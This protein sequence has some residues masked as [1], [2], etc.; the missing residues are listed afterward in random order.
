[1]PLTRPPDRSL[2][3][4][5]WRSLAAHGGDACAVPPCLP[6]PR[7]YV[8]HALRDG[9]VLLALARRETAPAEA[10][11]FL[12]RVG[13]VLAKY[14]GGRV[15]EDAIRESFLRIY[16]VLEEV[17]DGGLPFVTEPAVLTAMLPPKSLVTRVA[18]AV[19][20]SGGRARE[21]L[22]EGAISDIPWRANKVRHASNEIYFDIVDT[23]DATMNA[24][25]KLVACEVFSRV[26]ANCKLSGMPDLTLA[27][28]DTSPLRGV[29]FN[30]CVRV[31][32]FR[33]DGVLS[34]V[35]PDGQFTLCDFSPPSPP[36]GM[37]PIYVTPQLAWEISRSD[38]R[39]VSASGS[40]GS[41]GGSVGGGGGDA[42]PGQGSIG[43]GEEAG[44]AVCSGGRLS[45]MVGVKQD[46][47]RGVDG[48]VVTI[49][50]P[51]AWG[52]RTATLGA[53]VGSVAW[54]S[55]NKTATWTVGRIPGDKA[56][57]LTGDVRLEDNMPPPE[58]S[59]ALRA[60]WRLL[61]QSVSGLRIESLKF[62]NVG[63]KPYKGSRNLCVAGC[64]EVRG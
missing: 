58:G 38:A 5:Y 32:R 35:P 36:A 55:Q 44:G 54:D 22:P 20:G 33:A 45:V 42:S 14:C 13:D 6:S 26:A 18:A 21:T 43:G 61:G 48:I 53:N 1:M 11:E 16:E 56:P 59:M 25:G 60:G 29:R 37:L 50:F 24:D 62:D 12:Q 47:G 63:Y 39:A 3:E 28:N 17:A 15:R 23:V 9:V 19:T 8:F 57:C 7:A 46:I 41:P 51:P 64:Y 10:L 2:C 30:P 34:F 4:V 52:V 40:G 31:K 49:P 27:F